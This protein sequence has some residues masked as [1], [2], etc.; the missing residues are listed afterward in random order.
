[1]CF[2]IPWFA[3]AGQEN[4]QKLFSWDAG[5]TVGNPGKYAL[6]GGVRYQKIVLRISDGFFWE[7]SATWWSSTRAE[8][9]YVPV[10]RRWYS[11]GVGVAGSYFYSQAPDSLALA[12]N[13]SLGI[14][15]L[16]DHQWEEWF[17]VGPAI[18]LRY[19]GVLLQCSLPLF[20]WGDQDR[21][22]EWRAG[23]DF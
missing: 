4:G 12:V 3:Y 6:T 10:H 21:R 2:F 17:G 16:V 11:L 19:W 1:M 22:I 23:L 18:S 7:K 8:L 5:V 15:A 13:K 14:Y 9:L 20:Q